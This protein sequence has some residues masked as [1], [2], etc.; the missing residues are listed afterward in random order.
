MNGACAL[1]R[2][3]ARP[4][5]PRLSHTLWRSAAVHPTSRTCC[6]WSRPSPPSLHAGHVHSFD[7]VVIHGNGVDPKDPGG[8]T[9]FYI[10]RDRI[11]AVATVGAAR[12]VQ[13]GR[14]TATRTASS[15]SATTRH[16]L[17][18]PFLPVLRA[19]HLLLNLRR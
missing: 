6:C 15:A 19:R 2:N 14:C 11:A 10:A 17:F 8:F 9:A 12:D 5:T 18:P 16:H 1:Q 3:N 13:V 7:R 4:P